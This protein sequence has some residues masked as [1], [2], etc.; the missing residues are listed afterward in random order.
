MTDDCKKNSQKKAKRKYIKKVK[1]STIKRQRKS[2]KAV[3]LETAAK[4]KIF[5]ELVEDPLPDVGFFLSPF[6]VYENGLSWRISPWI[7]KIMNSQK[8]MKKKSCF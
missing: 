8:T 6:D 1:T 2:K 5:D 3:K 7:L 4:S